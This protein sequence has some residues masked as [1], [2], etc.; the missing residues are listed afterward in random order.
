MKHRNTIW[1]KRNSQANGP[2]NK[3]GPLVNPKLKVNGPFTFTYCKVNGLS[4][5]A[6]YYTDKMQMDQIHSNRY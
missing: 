3:S 4:I 1:A 6:F 5:W 2:L